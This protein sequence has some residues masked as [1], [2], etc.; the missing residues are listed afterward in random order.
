MLLARTQGHRY[1]VG[2]CHTH[3]AIRWL[4]LDRVSPAHLTTQPA[5]RIPIEAAGTPPTTGEL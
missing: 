5:T 1:L 4:R 3:Q 2:H